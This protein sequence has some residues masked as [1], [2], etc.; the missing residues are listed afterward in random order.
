MLTFCNEMA[1]LRQSSFKM[2]P[3]N[4][5]Q[6]H[7]FQVRRSIKIEFQCSD[8]RKYADKR[9]LNLKS[10]VELTGHVSRAIRCGPEIVSG[11]PCSKRKYLYH[12]HTCCRPTRTTSEAHKARKTP[13]QP[14]FTQDRQQH[15]KSFVVSTHP[16]WMLQQGAPGLRLCCA[17]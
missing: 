10:F 5:P 11:F 1:S 3:H 2:L 12:T 15:S 9:Q 14:I 4:W 16:M 17:E 13:V 6:R 7:G 8:V